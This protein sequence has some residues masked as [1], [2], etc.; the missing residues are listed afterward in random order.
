MVQLWSAIAVAVL[1]VFIGPL[2]RGEVSGR[3]A[4]RIATHS[5]IRANI[6]DT[7][8]A[9]KK[10]DELLLS[11][12]TQLAERETSRLTRRINGGNVAALV[13]VAIAGGAIVYGLISAAIALQESGWSWIFWI[14][15][16]LVA[17]FALALSAAGLGSLYAPK[18]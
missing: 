9:A 1:T 5:Q 16:G 18:K 15:A 4:R 14:V 6:P 13:F 10:L 8:S 3:L 7:S 2:L 12:V 17:V 11:E